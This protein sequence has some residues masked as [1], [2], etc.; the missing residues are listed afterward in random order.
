MGCGVRRTELAIGLAA[1]AQEGTITR[2]RSDTTRPAVTMRRA[3]TPVLTTLPTAPGT[4]RIET[5]FVTF[6]EPVL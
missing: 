4:A 1:G 6:T 2:L 5:D 3:S